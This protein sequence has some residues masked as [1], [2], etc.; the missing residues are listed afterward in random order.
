MSVAA[1]V[2]RRTITSTEPDHL[3]GYAQVRAEAP[4]Y[5]AIAPYSFTC[6]TVAGGKPLKNVAD[7]W[8]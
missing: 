1:E 8:L 5:P 7:A 2:T 6:T 3:G 4:R